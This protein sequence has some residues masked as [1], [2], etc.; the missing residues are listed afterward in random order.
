MH[1]E[2]AVMLAH[3]VLA[4][5]LVVRVYDNVG[6]AAKEME[7]ALAAAHAVLADAGIAVTWRECPREACQDLGPLAPAEIVVR[8]IAAPPASLPDSLGFSLVDVERRAGTLATVFTDR[9][10]ALSAL[11]GTA[12]GQLLGRAMAHEIGHL[13]L[14]TTHHADRGL[15]RGLWTTSDLKKEQPWDWVLSR[16]D[17]ARMRRGLAARLRRPEQPAAI[18]AHK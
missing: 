6:I 15:M 7:S 11:A 18:V 5:S 16:E 3:A 2:D 14:G 8:V 4:L 9:V 13:L 17:G 1:R 12:S 10:D